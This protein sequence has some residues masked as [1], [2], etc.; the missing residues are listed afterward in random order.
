MPTLV[1]S[2]PGDERYVRHWF[3]WQDLIGLFNED[4]PG[5]NVINSQVNYTFLTCMIVIGVFAS[6]KRLIVALLLGRQT[7]AHFGTELA[8]GKIRA[9]LLARSEA[10]PL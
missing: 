4:N 10:R 1:N 5:G 7:F 8:T 3:Y 6:I 9:W 2:P